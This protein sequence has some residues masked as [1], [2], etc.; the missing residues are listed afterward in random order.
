LRLGVLFVGLGKRFT[1][2]S[3]TALVTTNVEVV[4]A[5]DKLVGIVAI[6]LGSRHPE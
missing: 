2:R 4:H 5:V 6:V 1:I 3:Y